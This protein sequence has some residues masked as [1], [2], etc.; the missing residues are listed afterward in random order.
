M[1]L[2]VPFLEEEVRD[3]IWSADGDN[4]LGPGGFN[5]IK[6]FVKEFF[7]IATLPKA[8]TASFLSLISKVENPCYLDDFRPICLIGSLY[9]ILATLLAHRLKKVIG[10]L[11]SNCQS[12]F[13]S[14]RNMLD[15]V[16][17]VNE[18]LDMAKRHNLE[19]MM[20]KVD[21][22]YPIFISQVCSDFFVCK[23]R[24]VLD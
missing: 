22:P 7:E 3:I 15:G 6:D 21:L 19:C 4:S 20:V 18:I 23:S 9:R 13:V 5:D 24:F 14:G 10:K 17:V 12:A 2:E 1:N 16:V 8:V 11:V